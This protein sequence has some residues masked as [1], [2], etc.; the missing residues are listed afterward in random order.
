[1]PR[2]ISDGYFALRWEVL[3]RDA[4]TC[5]YCG[6]SAPE[7]KLEVDHITPVCEG[8]KDTKE[9]LVTSCYS[10]NRGKSALSLRNKV[11]CHIQNRKQR[12]TREQKI[13]QLLGENP[14]GLST[15]QIMDMLNIKRSNADVIISKLLKQG[16]IKRMGWRGNLIKG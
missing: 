5:Q 9:N 7:V 1:M 11:L 12:E 16:K 8:G 2:N 6:R 10:C 15:E 4:F 3:K 13:D 14:D